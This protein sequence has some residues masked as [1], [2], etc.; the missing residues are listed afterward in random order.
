MEFDSSAE[1][2]FK[3][4]CFQN[5][6]PGWDSC[7]TGYGVSSVLGLTPWENRAQ[8]YQ[9]LTEGLPKR[10]MTW[11]MQRGM[12][13]KELVFHTFGA[14][15]RSAVF[16]K[17][18]FNN[19]KR[20]YVST[21]KIHGLG[22][23]V[24]AFLVNKEDGKVKAGM[25]VRTSGLSMAAYWDKYPALVHTA[26]NIFYM[27]LC[28]IG[29]WVLSVM[30]FRKD[31]NE[32]ERIPYEVRSYRYAFDRDVFNVIFQKAEDF[33]KNCYLA[34]VAPNEED[35]S[36]IVQM[37]EDYTVRKTRLFRIKPPIAQG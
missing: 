19:D 6:F 20:F 22:G 7:L 9:R 25:T 35:S 2:F 8:L 30:L 32:E 29:A 36:Q 34:G 37:L 5:G 4:P 10:E 24:D 28:G 27:G 12:Q 13:Y 11:E 31:E 21:D 23:M 17:N 15:S 14:T 16:R 26:Q 33:W 3:Q 1:L 18:P